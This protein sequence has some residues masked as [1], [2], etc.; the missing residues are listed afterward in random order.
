MTT[1]PCKPWCGKT[2]FSV[3]QPGSF[4]TRKGIYYCRDRCVRAAIRAER[5][6]SHPSRR[7]EP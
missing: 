5:A 1:R 6:A 7:T 4:Y 3:M 2:V